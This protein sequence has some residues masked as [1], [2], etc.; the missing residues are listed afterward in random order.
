MLEEDKKKTTEESEEAH[1]Q[2]VASLEAEKD[3]VVERLKNIS[4]DHANEI[5]E[6][7]RRLKACKKDREEAQKLSGKLEA[8]KSELE[9]TIEGY[10][11]RTDTLVERVL[12][13]DEKNP[14]NGHEIARL[15]ERIEADRKKLVRLRWR[16]AHTGARY[17]EMLGRAEDYSVAYQGLAQKAIIIV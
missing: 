3:Q 6:L 9:K 11:K 5:L 17:L 16:V 7:N 13:D 8:K 10:Q 2:K 4:A 15:K 1:A 14:E 12:G